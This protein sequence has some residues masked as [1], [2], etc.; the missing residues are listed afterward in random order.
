[1]YVNFWLERDTNFSYREKMFFWTQ[2]TSTNKKFLLI[3][4]NL[5]IFYW[6]KKKWRK[7]AQ[8]NMDGIYSS[9]E[10]FPSLYIQSEVLIEVEQF[11][12]VWL[13]AS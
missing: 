8:K 5:I 10:I 2:K 11:Y 7:N 12:L 13:V 4:N 3:Y 1:M 6:K 9:D